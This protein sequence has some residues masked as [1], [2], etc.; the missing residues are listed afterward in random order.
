VSPVRDRAAIGSSRSCAASSRHF[1]R[2]RLDTTGTKIKVAATDIEAT[3]RMLASVLC[4]AARQVAV[5]QIVLRA[6]LEIAQ[7][8]T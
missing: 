3:N 2:I 6:A 8:I 5:R 4:A 1:L 7:P